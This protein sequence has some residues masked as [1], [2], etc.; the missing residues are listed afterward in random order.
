MLC[1]ATLK[2]SL[3]IFE[4][5]EQIT[6]NGAMDELTRKSHMLTGSVGGAEG[7]SRAVIGA[8]GP[9]LLGCWPDLC[10]LRRRHCVLRP[11]LSVRRFFCLFVD[12]SLTFICR[13]INKQTRN[14][15]I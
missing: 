2:A 14:G 6:G 12:S 4:R 13:A 1:M 3:D 11:F 5:V 8:V 9:P 7:G 15:H 10:A